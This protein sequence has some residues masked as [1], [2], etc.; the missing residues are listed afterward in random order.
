VLKP[1]QDAI[2]AGDAIRA[3]IWNTGV[4]QDGRTRGITMPNSASQEELIRTVYRQAQIDP[5]DTGYVEAHGTGTTVGDPAEA[6]A[7]SAVFCHGKDRK[8]PLL[9]GSVKSNV[10]HAEGASGIV[11]IIKTA[12]MLER[13]FILP[14]CGVTEPNNDIPMKEWNMKVNAPS[15]STSSI[16]ADNSIRSPKRSPRGPEGKSMPVS[17]ISVMEEQ[18]L[19]LL[20]VN[21]LPFNLRR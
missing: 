15:M 14:N 18:T 7:L 6:R 4:N 2:D 9:I 19:M 10:G 5:A 21:H 3:V 8:S 20:W 16:E 11:A 1:L 13:G 17:I 12:L